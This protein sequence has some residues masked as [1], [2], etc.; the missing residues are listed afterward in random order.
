[1]GT[2]H[3]STGETKSSRAKTTAA[4]VL[5]Y[6][7]LILVTLIALFPLYLLLIN[8]TRSH[9]EIGEKFSILPSTSF[10]T[11]FKSATMSGGLL[12]GII[13]SFIISASA[14]ILSCYFSAMTAYGIHVYDFKLK[15]FAFTFIMVIMM[16]PTQISAVGFVNLVF[17]LNLNDTFVPLIV[18]SI[19]APAVF[20][21]MK[22][23]I[24]S[25]M[26]LEV[27]EAARVDGSNEFRTFNTIALPM[28]KPAIA[29]QLIFAFTSAWNNYF[30]P[31]LIIERPEN[32]TVPMLIATL[33]SDVASG[34][35]AADRG[36]LYMS[37]VIAIIP[38]VIVYIF[39]SKHIVQGVALGAVK[40]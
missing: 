21:Y 13:N 4:R 29:V 2:T 18:P 16:I 22:Q 36:N 17:N 23:Y 40:G 25:S 8:S 14:S 38:I 1:M 28:L 5:S 24:E 15:K 20:F 30:I 12:R 26:P 10:I 33:R 39:I 35:A 6:A 37:I 27:I 9:V 19:A 7:F 32:K 11:N 31:M 34:G 3:I